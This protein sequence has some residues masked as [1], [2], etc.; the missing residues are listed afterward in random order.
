MSTTI[1]LKLPAGVEAIA[2][3]RKPLT[4]RT[5]RV[6]LNL[7]GKPLGHAVK[8]PDNRG[9][10]SAF[11]SR[12]VPSGDYVGTFDT[13][14]ECATALV[15]DHRAATIAAEQEVGAPYAPEVMPLGQTQAESLAGLAAGG[16]LGLVHYAPEE[17]GLSD[18]FRVVLTD[19][20]VCALGTD[21]VL[22]ERE[23]VR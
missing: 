7:D 8:V 1:D 14:T 3:G 22:V 17:W 9:Q 16:L 4:T 11:R 18:A 12:F 23:A 15:R 20:S 19:G 2:P 21:G 13:V 10:W 6:G 5:Q